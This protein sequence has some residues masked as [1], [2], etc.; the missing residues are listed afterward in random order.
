MFNLKLYIKN[1]LFSFGTKIYKYN[2][3]IN[4]SIIVLHYMH[5]FKNL[6]IKFFVIKH[7]INYRVVVKYSLN[8][9][10]AYTVKGTVLFTQA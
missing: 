5:G 1:K 8:T 4:S 2:N 9:Y 10:M 7:S 6:E 3:K